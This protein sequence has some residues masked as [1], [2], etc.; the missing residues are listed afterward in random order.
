MGDTMIVRAKLGAVVRRRDGGPRVMVRK[1]VTTAHAGSEIVRTHPHLWEPIAVDH[2]VEGAELT[3]AAVEAAGTSHT[4]ALRAIAEGLSARGYDLVAASREE[5]PS[6]LVALVFSAIDHPRA[7]GETHD[8]G[9]LDKV[10]AALSRAIMG[11]SEDSATGIIGEMQNAGILFRERT[12]GPAPTEP[13]C[14]HPKCILDHPHA[15]PAQLSADVPGVGTVTA[16]EDDPGQTGGPDVTPDDVV[17][18]TTPEGRKAI[19][20]WAR[21]YGLDVAASGPIPQ[22]V[23]DAWAQAQGGRA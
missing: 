12:E 14:E 15:G 19:R 8:P 7:R 16:V 22:D 20:A 3:D 5:V 6:Q 18:P 11:L 4:E 9:T 2:P 1:G 13:G 23:V 10:R 21:D 17:D